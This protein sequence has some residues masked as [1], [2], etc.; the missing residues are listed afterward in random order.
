MQSV[1]N[2]AVHAVTLCDRG[3]Q[4]GVNK[5]ISGF[6][7]T[8]RLRRWL[9]LHAGPSHRFEELFNL[10]R[11]AHELMAPELEGWVLD[12]IDEGHKETPRVWT[13]HNEP[14]KQD[15][16]DLFL[17]G[18]SVCFSEQVQ[19]RAAE[20]VSVAVGV[21]QLVRNGIQEKVPPFGVQVHG[22]IL[23]DVHV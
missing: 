16:C 17:D 9:L 2:Q 13:I 20:V 6:L 14:L 10:R 21:P 23:E 11:A 22:Q 18:F 12:E 8:R 7:L 4:S 3:S 5:K 15:P 19:Q 1:E